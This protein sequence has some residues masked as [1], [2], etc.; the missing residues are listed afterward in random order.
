M[1]I[2]L[3]RFIAE[4]KNKSFAELLLVLMIVIIQRPFVFF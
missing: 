2:S 1:M 3:E 4:Y